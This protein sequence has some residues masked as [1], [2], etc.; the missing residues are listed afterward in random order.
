M[1]GHKKQELHIKDSE[2]L[3]TLAEVG[4]RRGNAFLPSFA[5]ISSALFLFSFDLLL[6]AQKGKITCFGL[7]I[8]QVCMC[9]QDASQEL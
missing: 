3:G 9:V 2:T 8:V 4:Q 5:P 1:Q 6:C 7:V